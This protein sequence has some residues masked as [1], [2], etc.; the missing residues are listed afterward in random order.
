MYFLNCLI[1]KIEIIMI[2][3]LNPLLSGS[4]PLPCR[5]QL[6]LA[7]LFRL[8]GEGLGAEQASQAHLIQAR[9]LQLPV[10]ALLCPRGVRDGHDAAHKHISS[11]TTSGTLFFFIIITFFFS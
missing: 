5:R 3:S 2:F 1:Q 4:P 9:R 8:P 10:H 7:A 6:W 11:R